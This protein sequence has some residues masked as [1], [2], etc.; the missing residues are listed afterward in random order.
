MSEPSFQEVQNEL[1]FG[2]HRTEC[3][4]KLMIFF[5][6]QLSYVNPKMDQFQPILAR[7][8]SFV[9]K[10]WRYLAYFCSHGVFKWTCREGYLRWDDGVPMKIF[11][12]TWRISE[13]WRTSICTHE[14]HL[15]RHRKKTRKL[16]FTQKYANTRENFARIFFFMPFNL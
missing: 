9:G 4:Y 5:N 3:S 6:L 13:Q 1:F 16:K 10:F 12:K 8:V 2:P 11:M 7:F 14:A 15:G